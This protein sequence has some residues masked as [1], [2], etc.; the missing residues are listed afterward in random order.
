MRRGKQSGE[1]T[2]ITKIYRSRQFAG[3]FRAASPH[4]SRRTKGQSMSRGVPATIMAGIMASLMLCPAPAPAQTANATPDIIGTWVNPRGTVK[5]RTGLCADRLCGWIVWA[6]PQAQADAREGGVSRLIGIE[7]LRDYHG[8][9]A[10]RYRGTVYV[11]DM[12]RTF[13]STIEQ[14]DPNRLRISGCVLGGL[15]CKSQ[16]WH[17]A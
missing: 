16:N 12:G 1:D 7:L 17:R 15:I 9:G 13:Y 10:N 3:R 11:P 4:A 14:R 5:V 2:K 6:A 8:A